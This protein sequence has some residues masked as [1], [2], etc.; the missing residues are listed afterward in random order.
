[1]E[2]LDRA[3]VLA[4]GARQG[5]QPASALTHAERFAATATLF[6]AELIWAQAQA[7]LEVVAER[8]PDDVERLTEHR[9]AAARAAWM[10][11]EE[12]QPETECAGITLSLTVLP[13]TETCEF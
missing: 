7:A 13:E 11:G 10:I 3:I 6:Q 1:M 12:L 2:I 9:A 8:N 4:D 5:L